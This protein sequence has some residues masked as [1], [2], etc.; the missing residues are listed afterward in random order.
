MD[1]RS[2]IARSVDGAAGAIDIGARGINSAV[3]LVGGERNAT[4]LVA[5]GSVL[6][7]GPYRAAGS[8]LF[9]QITGPFAQNAEQRL[10]GLFDEHVFSRSGAAPEASL[11]VSGAAAS[12]GV[13]VVLGGIFDG[14]RAIVE[15]SKRYV[16]AANQLDVPQFLRRSADPNTGLFRLNSYDLD[17]RWL[18]KDGNVQWIDPTDPTMTLRPLLASDKVDIDHISRRR[19]RRVLKGFPHCPRRSRKIC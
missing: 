4:V 3:A 11:T 16:T 14:A 1:D 15:G 12:I 9:D 19:L 18:D 10:T 17:R 7:M 8:I 13:N 2:L 5:G 6:L